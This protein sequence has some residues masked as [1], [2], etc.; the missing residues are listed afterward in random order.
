MPKFYFTY[1]T[2]PSYPFQGGWTEVEAPDRNSAD[3][4][5][6]LFHPDRIPGILNCAFVYTEE[7]FL[8]TNLPYG[9]FGACC[10]EHIPPHQESFPMES[11]G[12]E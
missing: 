12:T 1:G 3:V 11:E 7:E 5:F 9:N 10:Q 8:S 2:D 6:R 4:L